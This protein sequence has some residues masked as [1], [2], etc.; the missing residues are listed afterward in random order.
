MS[1]IGPELPPHLLAKRKRIQE[2]EADDAP[3]TASGAKPSLSPDSSEKRRRVIGPAMPPA[4]LDE[5]PDEPP[6]RF[7]E[8]ES[9]DEDGFG[10]TLPPNSGDRVRAAAWRAIKFSL[11]TASHRTTRMMPIITTKMA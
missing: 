5:R 11:L 2:K 9:E 6:E 8:S 10:P 4:P 1:A 7:E 3:T